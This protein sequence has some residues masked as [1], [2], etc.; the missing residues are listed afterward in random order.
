MIDWPALRDYA[1]SLAVVIGTWDYA[2]LGKVPAARW[3][4]EQPS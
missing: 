2:F 4:A 1:W 3:I